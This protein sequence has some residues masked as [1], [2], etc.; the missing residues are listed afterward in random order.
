M[1]TA[2]KQNV[3]IQKGGLIQIYSPDL[4]EGVQAEVIIL[5]DM[6]DVDY[7]DAWSAEDLQDVT[8]YSLQCAAANLGEVYVRF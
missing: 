7:S 2:L 5:F 4:L 8:R 1:Q 3:T 6:K